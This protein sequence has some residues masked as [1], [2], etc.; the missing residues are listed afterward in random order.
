LKNNKN[1]LFFVL[2]LAL[3]GC[4]GGSSSGS[5]SVSSQ[6]VPPTPVV[7]TVPVTTPPPPTPTPS[8]TSVVSGN[9]SPV[10]NV[11][12]D[13]LQYSGSYVGLYYAL[14]NNINRV[15][16]NSAANELIVDGNILPNG[17]PGLQGLDP[18][19]FAVKWSIPTPSEGDVLAV[20]D[21][22]SKAF[23]G[24]CNQMSLA[25]VDLVSHRID[26]VF[27]VNLPNIPNLQLCADDIDI[28]PGN[29]SVVAVTQLVLNSLSPR[30]YG[31]ALYR[32]GIMLPDA[33]NDGNSMFYSTGT[34]IYTD[35]FKIKFLG[36]QELIG[37][38]GGQIEKYVVTDSGITI[39]EVKN[40]PP[41]GDYFTIQ[42]G[43]V[44]FNIG[45]ISS[46]TDLS[47]YK[48]FRHCQAQDASFY[49]VATPDPSLPEIICATSVPYEQRLN[50]KD[51]EIEIASWSLNGERAT[52]RTRLN[53]H[54]VIQIPGVATAEVFLENM[55]AIPGGKIILHVSDFQSNRM[56]LISIDPTELVTVNDQTVTHSHAEQNGVIVDQIN[57]PIIQSSYDKNSNR[58]Y[59]IVSG[60]YGSKGSSLVA[61][62]NA[63]MQPIG[64]V[65]LS[66]EPTQ[67]SVST[68]GSFGYVSDG[69]NNIQQIDLASMQL[70]WSLDIVDCGISSITTRPGYPQ[71]LTVSGGKNIH[72][73]D[74]GIES[75][76]VQ[77]SNWSGCQNYNLPNYPS[78][79]MFTD[80]A[81]IVEFVP[82]IASSNV[83]LYNVT[84]GNISSNGQFDIK[85]SMGG[86]AYR[87]F[88]NLGFIYNDAGDIA[89]QNTLAIST[90]APSMLSYGSDPTANFSV[91]LPNSNLGGSCGC[92]PLTAFTPLSATRFL[93]VHQQLPGVVLFDVLTGTQ[94]SG[95]IFMTGNVIGQSFL[96]PMQI[97]DY[98]MSF[99]QQSGVLGMG[100]IYFVRFPY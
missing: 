14:I 64:F 71:Q 65:P 79:V 69:F 82:E 47:G 45:N 100:S 40:T 31:T 99:S 97:D 34:N 89:D 35:S 61:I 51:I 48:E 70:G 78:T 19:T 36:P 3:S 98:T 16:Y 6:Q 49:S 84:T 27:S 81:R 4:G 33:V 28:R 9:N 63:T 32:N 29:P 66:Y 92:A 57:L 21:D 76:Y 7:P 37:F 58:T 46:V 73:L 75:N 18:A 56:L 42:N 11:P 72:L 20:S 25:Q 91:T 10:L 52:R 86:G 26:T 12:N 38:S 43:L 85:F 44:Y 17:S 41:L 5:G 77:R 68:D 83:N 54:D 2:L 67:L 22:G 88:D 59:G 62:D 23:V 53:L 80:S 96:Q 1:I 87:D 93:G 55:I 74:G 8:N 24:L 39:M 94:L 60:S 15:V 95:R 30:S 50:P 13:T 90:V